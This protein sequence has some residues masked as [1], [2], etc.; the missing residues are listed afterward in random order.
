[1]NLR[2]VVDQ[3]IEA[4]GHEVVELNLSDGPHS[5]QRGPDAHADRS[6]LGQDRIKDAIAEF[7]EQRT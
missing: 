6:A 4:G 3:L 1:M 5:G 7:V 2:R